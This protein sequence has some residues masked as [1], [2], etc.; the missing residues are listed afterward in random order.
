MMEIEV[1]SHYLLEKS[2]NN[3]PFLNFFSLIGDIR[4]TVF[5]Q[6]NLYLFDIIWLAVNQHLSVAGNTLIQRNTAALKLMLTQYAR[7]TT[8]DQIPNLSHETVKHKR[9]K[10]ECPSIR[11]VAGNSRQTLPT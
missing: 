9:C 11:F 3:R 1:V 5:G 2:I 10:A 8:R 6:V 7:V 4:N